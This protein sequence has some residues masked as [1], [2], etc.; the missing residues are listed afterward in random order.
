MKAYNFNFLY[1]FP[2]RQEVQSVQSA[3]LPR[4]VESDARAGRGAVGARAGQE[5]GARGGGGLPG[6][7]GKHILTP[8]QERR[9]RRHRH[10]LLFL[11]VVLLF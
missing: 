3:H 8:E 1:W 9:R 10:N 5:Q 6:G 2:R 11:F 7:A 4:E